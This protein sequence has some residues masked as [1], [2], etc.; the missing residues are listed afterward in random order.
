[1]FPKYR[2]KVTKFGLSFNRGKSLSFWPEFIDK[3]GEKQIKLKQNKLSFSLAL[4]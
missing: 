4:L 1:M 2:K 3:I